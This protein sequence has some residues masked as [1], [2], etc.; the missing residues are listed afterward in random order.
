MYFFSITLVAM[1]AAATLCTLSAL[2][3]AFQGVPY[4]LDSEIPAAVF[5]GLHLLITDPSTSPRS[6]LGKAIFGF[7]YGLGVFALYAILGAIGVPTFY[8]KLLCVPLLNLCVIGIDHFAAS[9]ESKNKTLATLKLSRLNLGFMAL[10]IV[11]F[12]SMAALGKTD[13]MHR[14]DSVPFWQSACAE[15]RSHACDRLLQIEQSYCNDGAAW[16]CNELGIEYRDG[17]IVEPNPDLALGYFS[18]SCELRFQAA[19]QNLLQPT[20]LLKSQPKTLDLRLMLRQGGQN[21]MTLD[22][23]QLMQRACDHAWLF[24]CM[25]ENAQGDASDVK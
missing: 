22:E 12:G 20:A 18:R 17:V 7:L 2:Y 19:C 23:N 15:G 16:A 6:V 11:L 25:S 14:G 4:F 1:M 21:L 13:S 24:A 3:S 10:W 9:M 5:L 8:D